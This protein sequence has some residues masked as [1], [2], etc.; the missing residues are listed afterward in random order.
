MIILA[1]FSEALSQVIYAVASVVGAS[2][3]ADSLST[4]YASWQRALMK[5]EDEKWLRE[6][7]KDPI[8]Y[9]NLKSYTTVC[10]QV[11][12]NARVGAFW[13]ALHEVTEDFR[14]SWNPWMAGWAVCAL[15]IV[16][17]MSLF[18]TFTPSMFERRRGRGR[19]DGGYYGKDILP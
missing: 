2:F 9:T 16:V 6:N 11:E 15:L 19:G 7:C 12:A 17:F 18:C 4:L 14:N 8:F 5:L 13:V 10:S 1:T 3:F